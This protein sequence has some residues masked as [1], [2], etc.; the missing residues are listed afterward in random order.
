MQTIVAEAIGEQVRRLTRNIIR[1]M[2]DQGV[3][4]LPENTH[5]DESPNKKNNA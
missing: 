2:V 1:D 3:L 5:P 4:Q